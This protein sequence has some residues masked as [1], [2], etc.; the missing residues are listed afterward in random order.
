MRA[1]TRA[2]ALLGL[3][4][5]HFAVFVRALPATPQHEWWGAAVLLASV[6][7]FKLMNGFESPRRAGRAGGYVR[8]PAASACRGG[9]PVV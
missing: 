4:A 9:R 2:V 6:A 7:V 3:L 5:V 1:V 8:A